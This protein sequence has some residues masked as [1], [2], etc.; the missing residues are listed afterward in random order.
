LEPEKQERII[1]A[2]LKEFVQKDY[3][4]ASTN[5][6]VKEAGISKG[7]LFHYFTS[8]KG[9]LL[10]LYD[11]S[12]QVVNDEF[13]G[14]INLKEKDVLER[15]RQIVLL[16]IDIIRKYPDMF[17]FLWVANSRTNGE[18][19]DEL[20]NRNQEFLSASYEKLNKGIDET[21]FR[22]GIDVKK[23][24]SIISWTI[25]GFSKMQQE[26]IEISNVAQ[27]DYDV[28]MAELDTFIDVLRRCFY[29]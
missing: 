11:Y 17:N 28:M 25:E 9:L 3:K 5:E 10:F 8:K 26:N 6:I 15:W 22:D 4:N 13:L 23:A 19:K 29:K 24:L 2:A 14:L 7:L 12:L 1:N 20:E 21:I 27:I 18:L 16:K